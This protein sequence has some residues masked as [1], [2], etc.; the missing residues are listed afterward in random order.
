MTYGTDYRRRVISFIHEGG[1]KREAARLFKVNPDTIYEW[2]KRGDDLSPRPA[3]TRRR[4]LDKAVLAQHVEE[5]PDALLRERAA[6]A[7]QTLDM[8]YNLVAEP[9]QPPPTGFVP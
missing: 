5:H 9:D 8:M 7:E 2:L 6:G 4:K 1:S 3:K